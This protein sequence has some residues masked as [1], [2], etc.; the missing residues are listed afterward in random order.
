MTPGQV[1]AVTRSDESDDEG[2]EEEEIEELQDLMIGDEPILPPT[3]I[4]A[5]GKQRS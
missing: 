1:R 5:T 4:P 3:K 2:E